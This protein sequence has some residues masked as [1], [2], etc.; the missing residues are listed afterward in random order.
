M[1]ELHWSC[2]SFF[3]MLASRQE[4]IEI[5]FLDSNESTFAWPAK[6]VMS[7]H[8]VMTPLINERDGDHGSVGGLFWRK[9]H[10]WS[11]G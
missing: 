2:H 9:L 11:S 6:P 3:D 8:P 5:G 7:E 1:L 10:G 4:R